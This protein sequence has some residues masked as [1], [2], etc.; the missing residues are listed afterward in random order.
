MFSGGVRTC[1]TESSHQDSFR[2]KK[3]QKMI[4]SDAK[5]L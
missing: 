2:Y 1:F 5:I 3:S 4:I